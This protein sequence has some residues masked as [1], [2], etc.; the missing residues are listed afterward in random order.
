LLIG[1][2][3]YEN[4]QAKKQMLF[5]NQMIWY[6]YGTIYYAVL[7]TGKPYYNTIFWKNKGVDPIFL[8]D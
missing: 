5:F 1:Y 4:H 6:F 8:S 2:F 3:F 7:S